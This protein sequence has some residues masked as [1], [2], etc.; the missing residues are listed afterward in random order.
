MCARTVRKQSAEMTKRVQCGSYNG[1]KNKAKLN[2]VA[3]AEAMGERD[4]M[5]TMLWNDWEKRSGGEAKV[6]RASLALAC[7]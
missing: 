7:A 5:A 6:V 4:D 1:L 3:S 2:P